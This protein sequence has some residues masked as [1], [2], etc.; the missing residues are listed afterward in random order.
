MDDYHLRLV[1]RPAGKPRDEGTDQSETHPGAI[2]DISARDNGW[3]EGIANA[4][5]ACEHAE[6]AQECRTAIEALGNRG[7]K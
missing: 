6:T 5:R 2:V 1:P 7:P 3:R 4:W